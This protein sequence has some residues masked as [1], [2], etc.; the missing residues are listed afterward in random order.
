MNCWYVLN[1]LIVLSQ[2]CARL[3]CFT[4]LSCALIEHTIK[5]RRTYQHFIEN[6]IKIHRK[7][8]NSWFPAQPKPSPSQL[9]PGSASHWK[10]INQE[11]LVFSKYFKGIFDDMFVFS[12]YFNGSFDQR[13]RT[14]CKTQQNAHV[15]PKYH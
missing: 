2:K 13:A 8:L 6:T 5:I 3:L 10:S 15:L 14:P 4:R 7:C 12:K 9:W 11:I 1:I